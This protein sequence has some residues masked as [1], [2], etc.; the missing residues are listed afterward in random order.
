MKK[1]IKTA[2]F[3][4]C[5]TALTAALALAACGKK[6]T[7]VYD[8]NDGTDK[9][10]A[11]AVSENGQIKKEPSPEREGYVFLGWSEDETVEDGGKYVAF[12]YTVERN[13]LLVANWAPEGDAEYTLTFETFGGTTYQPVKSVA[14]GCLEIPSVPEKDGYRFGGWFTDEELTKNFFFETDRMPAHDVTVYA[15]WIKSVKIVFDTDGGSAVKAITADGGEKIQAPAAPVKQGYYFAGWYLDGKPYEFGYMPYSDITLKAKWRE[16]IS[17]VTLTLN[18]NSEVDTDVKTLTLTSLEEGKAVDLDTIEVWNFIW[19]VNDNFGADVFVFGGWYADAACKT[20]FTSLPYGE[21]EVNAYAKWVRNAA[22]AKVSVNTDAGTDVLYLRKGEK[23]P[24]KYV[25][26]TTDLKYCEV[27]GYYSASG[28][29][30]GFADPVTMDMELYPEVSTKHLRFA[31]VEVTSGVVGYMV[32]V[33]F[34]ADFVAEAKSQTAIDL[35]IPAYHDGYEVRGVYTGDTTNGGFTAFAGYSNIISLVLPENVKFIG[36]EAFKNCTRLASAEINSVTSFGNYAFENCS[37]LTDVDINAA[38]ITSIGA[39]IFKGTPYEGTLS[40]QNG[41]ISLGEKIL[42]AYK[43]TDFIKL[44]IPQ[45]YTVIAGEAFADTSLRTIEKFEDSKITTIGERAFLNCNSLTTLKLPAAV[46]EIADGTFSGCGNLASVFVSAGTNLTSIGSYAF[47]GCAKLSSVTLSNSVMGLASFTG[48]RTIGDYAFYGTV[49]KNLF[50]RGNLQS[51]G[52]YA[53]ANNAQFEYADMS[54]MPSLTEVGAHAFENCV[55]MKYAIL[56]MYLKEVAPYT[57]YNCSAMTECGVYENCRMTSVG[58]SAFE[59]CNLKLLSLSTDYLVTVGVNAFKNNVNL[60][61]AKLGSSTDSQL[62]TVEAGAFAGCA[63]LNRIILRSGIS[64]GK[65]VEFKNG[66]IDPAQSLNFYVQ[67]GSPELDT[68]SE[69][70]VDGAMMS[71]LNIYKGS[72][73][74]YSNFNFKNFDDNPPVLQ[75]EESVMEVALAD[76]DLERVNVLEL[77]KEW[78]KY[79]VIDDESPAENCIITVKSVVSGLFSWKLQSDGTYNFS[80]TTIRTFNVSFYA[81][82]EFGNESELVTVLLKFV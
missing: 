15:K 32:V 75:L 50:I 81:A 19:Q 55:A 73:S 38:A 42:Y 27:T 76:V 53:F 62:K 65:A 17:D 63:K 70:F 23:L 44:T 72:L 30:I 48:L 41:F 35:R 16:P 40:G 28:K 37:A 64:S 46:T 3:F 58:E 12:P 36:D 45:N 14:N 67:D 49:I 26:V 7:V 21:S 13:V 18:I 77:L 29:K 71:Y 68:T 51:I 79:T 9:M 43:G 52:E 39:K 31:G 8:Y 33:G 34:E 20:P 56:P 54:Y 5:I 57:F 80:S 47:Y 59:N 1:M 2:L 11:V 10:R 6:F 66:W 69:Y 61:N 4:L 60:T 22:Y 24:E 74:G 78:G 82:D 25:D